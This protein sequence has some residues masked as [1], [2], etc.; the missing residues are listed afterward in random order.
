M[1]QPKLP[2][3]T[4]GIIVLNGHPFT[5]YCL[6]SIYHFAYEIIVVEGGHEDARSVCTEDGHSI[7]GTLES[8]Y[9]FKKDEDPDSKLTIVTR[10]SFWPKKDEL[11]RDRTPQSRAYAELATG[12]YLWQIDIDEF[13]MKS[14]IIRIVQMLSNDPSITAISFC[15]KVFWGDIKYGVDGNY[16]RRIRGGI[17]RLFKWAPNYKYLTHEPPTIIDENGV[18]LRTKHWITGEKLAK[19]GIYQFHY[20]L[21]FPWQ[22]EQKVKIYK[23]EKPELCEKMIEWADNNYFKISNPYRVHNVYQYPS[24]LLRYNESHPAEIIKM[25]DDIRNQKIL[26][27]IRQIE[28]IEILLNKWWYPLGRIRY[29]ILDF[30]I[31][32]FLL[33]RKKLWA[34]KAKIKDTSRK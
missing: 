10:D 22:V 23:D 28:D 7:D 16:L 31:F 18:D 24:W 32:R 33:I 17:H 19:L 15:Q 4:F 3:I 27:K 30:F 11:G 14:D 20:C 29:I 12:D 8:L 2:K 26:V 1:K 34:M 21:L 9:K 25:M 6:R 5:P 13:Y